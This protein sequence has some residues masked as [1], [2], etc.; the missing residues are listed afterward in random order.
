[1]II[2]FKYLKSCDQK[3]IINLINSDKFVEAARINPFDQLLID[4]EYC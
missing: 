2:D 3:T 4:K 1:M